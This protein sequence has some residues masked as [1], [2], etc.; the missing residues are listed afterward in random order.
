MKVIRPKVELMKHEDQLYEFIERVGRTCYKSEDKITEGS[1]KKFVDNL[2]FNNH[3]SVLEHEYLYFEF[4]DIRDVLNFMSQCIIPDNHSYDLL[5]YLN[6]TNYIIS[7]NARAWLEFFMNVHRMSHKFVIG[8][9]IYEMMHKMLNEKYPDLF[10]LFGSWKYEDNPDADGAPIG[11]IKLISRQE[12]L[13]VANEA[14]VLSKILPHT[15]KFVADRGF[16]AE[17]TRHRVASFCAESTRFCRYSSEKFGEEITVIKPCFWDEDNA[18]YIAWENSCKES[19]DTYIAMLKNGASPEQA[20]S[21]LPNSLKTEVIVTATE[22]EWQH[23]LDLRFRGTSG[24]PHPQMFEVM[25]MA[26]DILKEE[27]GGRVQ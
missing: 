25:K 26:R 12:V 15:I 22:E 10:I 2:A 7:G 21:V 13:E 24:T 23:I 4:S 3:L 8:T 6:I 11:D 20:R 14:T 17:I 16:L 27:T 1:A 5:R 18:H 9:Y 19:E